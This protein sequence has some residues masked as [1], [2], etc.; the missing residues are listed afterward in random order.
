[1]I[2]FDLCLCAKFSVTP[3]EMNVYYC[4]CRFHH[5]VISVITSYLKDICLIVKNDYMGEV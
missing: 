5:R 3:L 2:L 4:I 1:M